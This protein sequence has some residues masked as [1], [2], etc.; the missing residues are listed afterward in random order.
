MPTPQ[1]PN[2]AGDE[3]VAGMIPT[4]IGLALMVFAVVI[5]LAVLVVPGVR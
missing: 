5:V 3:Q 1:A 4:R 2:V